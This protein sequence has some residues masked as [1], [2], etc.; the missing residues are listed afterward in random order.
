MTGDELGIKKKWDKAHLTLNSALEKEIRMMREQLA[1]FHQEELALLEQNLPQWRQIAIERSE[2]TLELK[3]L[4]SLRMQA[5][6]E[7]TKVS[8]HLEK[9]LLPEEDETSCEILT[10][11]DQIVALTDRMNLQN[12]RN[13]NLFEQVKHRETLTLSC[14]VP[15]PL[16][17]ARRRQTPVATRT[18]KHP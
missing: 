16:H 10:K 12:C 6:E 4:R 15:H 3:E 9:E 1:N 7:L 11:I 17:T 18:K 2:N 5:T 8:V 14:Q 13:E